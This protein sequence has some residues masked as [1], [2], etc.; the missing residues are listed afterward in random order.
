MSGYIARTGFRF[1]DLY[2][3]L[4]VLRTASDAL[5][6]AWQSNAHDVIQTIRKWPVRFGIE[7]SPVANVTNDPNATT[8]DWDVLIESKTKFEFA[9]VKS[10]AIPKSDRLTFWVRLRREIAGNP[11]AAKTLTPV[12]VVD[13]QTA[14][15]IDKWQKLPTTALSFGGAPPSTEPQGNVCTALDLISEA[16]WHLSQPD[17]STDGSDPAV[18]F[19]TAR[20]ILGRFEIHCFEAQQLES[21]VLQYIELLFPGG[22]TETQQRLLLGWLGERATTAGSGRRMFTIDE[23]LSEIG[24]LEQSVSLQ[25]GAIREWRN[26]LDDVPQVVAS[27][28][29]F[30]LG[31][32]GQSVAA[33]IVQPEALNA[34]NS[35]ADRSLVLLGQ[36]GVGKSTF[37]AQA[38]KA[39]EQRGDVIFHCGADDVTNDE[40]DKV[41]NAVRFRAAMTALKNPT[42]RVR[43][44]VDGLDEAGGPLRKR[45]GQVLPRIVAL[46]NV[47]AVVSIREADWKSDGDVRKQLDSWQCVT[48]NLWPEAIVRQLLSSTPYHNSIPQTVIDLLRTPILLDLFWRAFVETT[49]PDISR[50]SKLQTRHHLLAEFW[51]QRIVN[52]PRHTHVSQLIRRL[53]D[54]FA[55]AASIVGPCSETHAD[56]EVIQLLLSEGVIVREGRLQP[57]LRFRHPLLRDFAYAQWCLG[58]TTPPETAQRCRGI[59]G[60][61]ERYAAMRALIE[62][63]SDPQATSEY[64]N[65]TLSTV[66]EAVIAADATM[67]AQIAQI[68]GTR[69]P[70]IHLDPS[71]WPVQSQTCLPGDF[72]RDLV[73]AARLDENGAWA[74]RIEHWPDDVTWVNADYAREVW[75]YCA[76]LLERRKLAPSDSKLKQQCEQATRKLRVLSEVPRFDAVFS[77][78]D[79]WLK[80]QAMLCVIPALPDETTL[81]WVEREMTHASWRTRSCVLERLAHLA[82]VDEARSATVYRQ[83]V[84]LSMKDGHPVIDIKLWGGVMDHQAIEWSLAGESGRRS[85]LKE[86]PATFLPVAL[87]LA[88][89][90]WSERHRERQ[91]QG[92]RIDELMR[93][94]DSSW[95]EDAAARHEQERQRRLGDL[96]DDSP[97]WSYWRSLPRDEVYERCLRAIHDC[98]EQIAKN[99]PGE[100]SAK[101][102]PLLRSSR[103][104]SVQTILIDL[105]LGGKQHA[106]FRQHLQQCVFDSRLYYVTGA[107]YWVEQALIICW[108]A[109]NSAERTAFFVLLLPI[110]QDADTQDA[111]KHLL[112]QLPLEEIPAE[113]HQF[114]PGDSDESYQ[115]HSRPTSSGVDIGG[116]WMPEGQSEIEPKIGEWPADFDVEKLKALARAAAKLSRQDTPREELKI[117]VPPAIQAARAV[118]PNLVGASALLR[119]PSRLWVL[120]G[121]TE[122]LNCFGKLQSQESSPEV[123]PGE[124]ISGCARLGIE[125][126]RNLPA[127]LQGKLPEGEVWTG[128]PEHPWVHAL[129]LTDAALAWPPASEDKAMQDEFMNLVKMAFETQNPLLQIVCTTTIRPWHWLRNKERKELHERLVWNLPKHASVLTWSL[130]LTSRYA[131]AERSRVFRLLLDRTDIENPKELAHRLGHHV[132]MWSIAV[133][134][135]G[136]RSAVAEI[137]RE[138]V[139]TPER[140]G[141]LLESGNRHEF[142]RHLVFG[143][144]EQAQHSWI[145]PQLAADYGDWALKIWRVLRTTPETKSRS[146]GIVLLTMHWLEKKDKPSDRSKLRLWWEALQPLFYA[147]IMTGQAA[148]CFTLFFNLREGEYNDLAPAEE[149]IELAEKFAERIGKGATDGTVNLDE[150]NPEQQSYHSWRECAD[151]VAEMSDSLRRDA[152]LESDLQRERAYRLLSSLAT[153]PVRSPKAL[154]ALHRLQNQ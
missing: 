15:E 28:T 8:P 92:N 64:P 79:R 149:L 37:V 14:G 114:R 113:L 141:L 133:F 121:L 124:L 49:T 17:K 131:D 136:N 11:D 31:E 154:E 152:L 100:F 33:T 84:G 93:Q 132:G 138:A 60:G 51:D 56:V 106:E 125:L 66:I 144:K 12:I 137:A 129:S 47:S 112:A 117:K 29:R 87:D 140:F 19:A 25:P 101:F 142:L 62:A 90:L 120:R 55:H 30:Q 63:L 34:L 146:E 143:M 70:S 1:Q 89:A 148:D 107:E 36:G 127:E 42:A 81:A 118:V 21:E 16:F 48:L 69:I 59:S 105:L 65:L 43:L 61:L 45:W 77:E 109:F 9:E 67:A 52:S 128:I 95:S 22:L 46:P 53:N 130:S 13:P 7:A 38:A 98:V 74:S 24:I 135:D 83:A 32:N 88:E 134:A 82:T 41:A 72:G 150:R 123:P 86:Y 80:M 10:G 39:A 18:P 71:K 116:E 115:P 139:N 147:V 78:S 40:L 27:R 2:L 91:T 94:F 57:R 35:I 85:L 44:F 20:E 145:Y 4:R 75:K 76:F 5:E 104:A 119:E 151:Y 96:I 103:L 99:S 50:A 6:Q 73:T 26:L 111:A 108:P 58:T 102:V 110:I 153:D 23:L 3:L 122:I 68:L 126:I 54:F 97:E